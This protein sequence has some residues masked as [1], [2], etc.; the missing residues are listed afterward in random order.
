M[1]TKKNTKK[2]MLKAWR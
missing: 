1:G 2:V